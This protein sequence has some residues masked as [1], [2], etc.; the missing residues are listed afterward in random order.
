MALCVVSKV[1]GVYVLYATLV[2]IARRYVAPSDEV[3]EPLRSVWVEL[4][5][6]GAHRQAV[7]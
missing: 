6:I 4:V 5:V 3:T 1:I 2:H 7:M